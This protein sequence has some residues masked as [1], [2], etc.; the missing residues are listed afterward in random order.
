MRKKT[1][2]LLTLMMFNATWA[3]AQ[4]QIFAGFT[5]TSGVGGTGNEGYPK[6]VDNK[7]TSSDWTKWCYTL[8]GNIITYVEF[9]SD[10]PFIPTSYIL[11]TGNDN[12]QYTGRNPHYWHLY[13]KLDENDAWTTL[14]DEYMNNTMKDYNFTDYEFNFTNPTGLP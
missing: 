11:T 8:P 13:A 1:L 2:L 9:H 7:F 3:M 4:S 14:A 12:Q 10:V 5:A 6:L